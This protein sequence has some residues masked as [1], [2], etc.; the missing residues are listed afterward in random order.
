M[1]NLLKESFYRD[2]RIAFSYKVAFYGTFI[3]LGINLFLF[4]Y[5]SKIVEPSSSY[6]NTTSYF[7]F[8]LYGAALTDFSIQIINSVQSQIRTFQTT[9]V[10]ES[11]IGQRYGEIPI[12]ISGAAYPSAF[13]FFRLFIYLFVGNILMET[14]IFN[15]NNM[16][17][18]IIALFLFFISII[19]ICLAASSMTLLLKKGN[20][21]AYIYFAMSTSLGGVVVPVGVFP[22]YLQYISGLLPIKHSLDIV[23]SLEGGVGVDNLYT[24]FISLALLSL[25]L[26]VLGICLFN[27]SVS[28][29][30]KTG[31]IGLY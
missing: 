6:I 4:F 25:A 26:L 19:G 12:I 14:N 1:F 22:E 10:I 21:I 11:L 15:L 3:N 9:G 30:K 20:P 24:S 28:V 31:T 27:H 2:F 5:F 16:V 7:V 13:G 23:R 18:S 29:S 17:Y 8:L